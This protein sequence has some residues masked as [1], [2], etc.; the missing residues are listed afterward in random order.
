LAGL[1]EEQAVAEAILRRL[2]GQRIACERDLQ[3]ARDAL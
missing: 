3:S 2:D 1:R